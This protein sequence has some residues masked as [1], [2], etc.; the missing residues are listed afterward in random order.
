MT[1]SFF[2]CSVLNFL[3]VFFFLSWGCV[4][5][6]MRIILCIP[7]LNNGLWYGWSTLASF[8]LLLIRTYQV[9]S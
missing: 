2:L 9:H 6:L 1:S 8:P 5:Q 3:I 4:F 7:L